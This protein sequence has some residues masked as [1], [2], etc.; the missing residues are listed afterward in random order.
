[1]FG[2]L[3]YIGKVIEGDIADDAYALS[4]AQAVIGP[5]G[6]TRERSTVSME[7]SPPSTID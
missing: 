7:G 2:N 1:V 3:L 4:C 6:D 5:R